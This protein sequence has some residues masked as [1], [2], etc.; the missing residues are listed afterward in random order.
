MIRVESSSIN[1]ISW[2]NTS[3][4]SP[5]LSS[6]I[7]EFAQSLFTSPLFWTQSILASAL[8][9]T[10]LSPTAAL[11]PLWGITAI[12]ISALFYFQPKTMLYEFSLANI[13]LKH[14]LSSAGQLGGMR[15][16]QGFM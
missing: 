8:T 10:A 9:I 16:C 3:A 12:S 7:A 2:N 1:A 5:S 11:A 6:R 14:A 13:R 15:S 4:A